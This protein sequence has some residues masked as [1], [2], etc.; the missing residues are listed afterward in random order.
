[1]K[2]LTV[3]RSQRWVFF[4]QIKQELHSIKIRQEAEMSQ[5]AVVEKQLSPNLDEADLCRKKLFEQIPLPSI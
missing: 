1:M 3:L 5:F 2:K 4:H